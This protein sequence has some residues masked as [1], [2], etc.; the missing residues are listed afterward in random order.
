VTSTRVALHPGPAVDGPTRGGVLVLAGGGY[1]MRAE[2]EYRD[3]TD[4]LAAQ[5]VRSWWLD[6]PVAPARYP[7]AL[8]EV[9]IA[10]AD[11]RA[12]RRGGAAVD[13]PLAVL[14]FSAGG[15]LAGTTATATEA[16]RA[17]AAEVAGLDAA[18][19][20]RPDAAVLCYPVVSMVRHPHV[21]SRLN[22]LGDVEDADARA[23]SVEARI[24]ADTPPTFLWHTA[25]DASVAVEHSLDATAALRRHHVPVE[26]HVYPSGRHGLGLAPGHP[27]GAWPGALVP[28]LASRGI[29]RA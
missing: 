9:L 24:D 18:E 28:W 11:L 1:A 8:H 6:Y 2:H 14:G 10:L 20:R 13:G 23:L 27:A 16:E 17:R 19:V 4:F 22:L 25:D 26:L 3:V 5:G 7:V 29:G 21:G 15:H 12:G